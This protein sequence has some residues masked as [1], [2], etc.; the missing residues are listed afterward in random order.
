MSTQTQIDSRRVINAMRKIVRDG[1]VSGLLD[2][3]VVKFIEDN[4]LVAQTNWPAT[5]IS[6]TDHGRD[7]ILENE[8]SD[9]D[10]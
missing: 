8:E 10:Q 3:N 9:D 4:N 1:F 7:Y 2:R 6:I 5:V